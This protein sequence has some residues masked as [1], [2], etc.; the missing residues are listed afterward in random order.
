M[1]IA[2]YQ[3]RDRKDVGLNIRV[4][5][6]AI[7]SC[8]ADFFCLPEYFAIPADYKEYKTVED[9]WLEITL[10]LLE[11][12]ATASVHFPGYVIAGSTVEKE[13]R[14]YYNTC[15]IFKDGEV[16]AKY[17]KINLVD[18]E[19]AL[20]LSPG[21]DVVKVKSENCTFSV[22][23]CA[24]CLHRETVEKAVQ[25]CDVLFLPVSMTGRAKVEGHPVSMRIA[26]SYGVTVVKVSRL[27]ADGFGVRSAVVTPGRVLEAGPGESVFVVEL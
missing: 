19:L 20:G 22:L 3:M 2:L 16:V 23:I 1:R 27:T 6:K 11:S 4:A 8:H 10:P 14:R 21:R 7:V 13:G 5:C 24:D 18:E 17:R 9:A 15:Y 25:G 12:L 26:E